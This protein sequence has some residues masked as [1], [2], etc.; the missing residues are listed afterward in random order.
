M[1]DKYEF[2][3]TRKSIQ[4]EELSQGERDKM[5]NRFVDVGGK[6]VKEKVV[7]EEAHR[8]SQSEKKP[9][10]WEQREALE[11]AKLREKALQSKKAGKNREK[12]QQQHP[13]LTLSGKVRGDYQHFWQ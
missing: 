11:N 2:D 7:Q 9:I 4:I 1:R 3:Q 5:F 6:V 13:W 10:T 8:H 12:S